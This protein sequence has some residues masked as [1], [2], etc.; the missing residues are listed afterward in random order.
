MRE[1]RET[2]GL[3]VR[4]LALRVDLSATSASY[5]SQLESGLK[6]PHSALARRLAAALEDDERIY[7]A[8]A[9]TSRRS[10]PIETARAVRTLAE[11]LGHARYTAV[12]AGEPAPQPR[13]GRDPGAPAPQPRTEPTPAAGAPDATGDSDSGPAEL[14][15]DATGYHGREIARP[16]PAI[17]A[18]AG[19]GSSQARMLVIEIEEGADPGEGAQTAPRAL[20]THRIAADALAGIEPPVRPFAFRASANGVSRV[21]D[22]LQ[23]GDLVI[24]SRRAWPI[25]RFAPYAVRLSGHLVLSRV[26]WNG[27]QLLLLPGR[28]A[29]DFMVLEAGDRTTLERRL[30]GKAIARVRAPDLPGSSA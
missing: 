4:A 21:S 12:A 29:S 18:G 13:G 11:T 26:L 16:L 6:T 25:E 9:A 2:L 19:A 24:L 7:L 5:L 30:A 27:R 14:L 28:D 3:T 20:A 8:W 22:A 17:P 10:D 1:R 15:S 23:A